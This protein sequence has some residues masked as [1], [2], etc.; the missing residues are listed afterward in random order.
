MAVSP[1]AAMSFRIVS[2]VSRTCRLSAVLASA[3]RPFFKYRT[4]R[5]FLPNRELAACRFRR[6][7]RQSLGQLNVRAPRVSHER[8]LDLA[9]G[10]GAQRYIELDPLGLELLNKR[11]QVLHF[12]PDMIQR[13]TLG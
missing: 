8:D 11:F 9:V 13:A 6:R 3:D 7:R 4:I 2:T 12:K 1:C 5:T 10:N